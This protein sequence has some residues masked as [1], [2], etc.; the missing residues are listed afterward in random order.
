MDPATSAYKPI[1]NYGVIGNLHTIALVSID[2]SI[3]WCC[4]PHF[5]SPSVFGAILDTK[6]GGHFNI[7]PVTQGTRRQTYLPDTNILITRFLHSDGAGEVIDFMPVSE[8]PNDDVNSHH[9]YRVVRVVKGKIR[10]QLQCFPAFN[11]AQTNFKI[12]RIKEG[13][14]FASPNMHMAFLADQKLR[15]EK[16]G[17]TGEFELSAGESRSFIICHTEKDHLCTQHASSEKALQDTIAYWRRWLSQINYQGRWR[18]SVVRSALTL[19]LLTFAPTGAI[20]AAP[21]MSLPERIGGVRNWDYRYTWIR[22][23]SFTLY[24]L[25]RLSFTKEAARFMDW[26]HARLENL[27]PDGSLNV[28][29][30]LHGEKHLTER[31]LKNLEGYK[32]SAPVRLGNAAHDQVQ[33]DIYGELMDSIYLFN[34]YGSPIPYDLWNSLSRMIDYVCHHWNKKDKGIWEIRSAPQHFTYSKVMCW[35]A[36]DR[37][38]RMAQKRSLPANWRLWI[39]TRDDIYRAVMSKGW[40]PKLR[41]FVQS[42]GSTAADASTLMLPLVKFISPTDPRMLGTLD[43]IKKTLVSDSLV[44]RYDHQKGVQDGVKGVEGTFS[45]CTFWYAEAL[46]RA[47]RLNEGRWI[48]EKMLGY[49]NHVGLFAEEVGPTGEQLGNFP[50]AFTHLALISAAINLNKALEKPSFSADGERFNVLG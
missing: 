48:F 12:A 8:D 4:L 15:Q 9:I 46:A 20:V 6:K 17:L 25:L 23:A 30:G 43:Y 41:S 3:D 34:K 35:V 22:D 13:Y 45:M 39:S 47:G 14:M 11:Y 38:I 7:T 19:K 28:M 2:G 29:Y 33:L 32:G 24:G 37:A 18:E 40:N 50:Q 44:F 49:A 16:N 27:N 1:E 10:F 36:V 21:T 31:V 26:L 5:D 42:F